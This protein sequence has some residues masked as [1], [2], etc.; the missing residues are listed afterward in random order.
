M[1]EAQE[2]ALVEVL[3]PQHEY[4]VW[5]WRQQGYSQQEIADGL[6]VNQST[7]QRRIQK[8]DLKICLAKIDAK[9]GPVSLK[10]TLQKGSEAY[11]VLDTTLKEAIKR[12]RRRLHVKNTSISDGQA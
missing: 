7:I 4:D 10:V 11:S 9:E 3:L 12:L 8:I 5:L 2:E 1:T 6:G